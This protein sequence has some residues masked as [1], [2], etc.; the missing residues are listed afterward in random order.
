MKVPNNRRE[1]ALVTAVV[2]V[3]ATVFAYL[4]ASALKAPRR[5]G[6]N[7]PGVQP[8][9]D[10]Q[11]RT[12]EERQIYGRRL[13]VHK[14]GESSS[15]TSK[16]ER[17][18]NYGVF[19]P[20][21]DLIDNSSSISAFNNFQ[22]PLPG[23]M[24]S[25][26]RRNSRERDDEQD[27]DG[28]DFSGW[29]WLFDDM[30]SSRNH[31]DSRQ[32]SRDDQAKLDEENEVARRALTRQSAMGSDDVFFL[33][34]GGLRE[35][36]GVE[37]MRPVFAD[38]AM[39]S[40]RSGKDGEIQ[41]NDAVSREMNAASGMAE[42]DDEATRVTTPLELRDPFASS[43]LDRAS[44]NVALLR[45]SRAEDV[46]FRGRE[47]LPIPSRESYSRNSGINPAVREASALN[48]SASPAADRQDWSIS[49]SSDRAFSTP[50]GYGAIGSSV[51][52]P[53]AG[54]FAMPS[55]FGGS[56]SFSAPAGGGSMPGGFSSGISTPSTDPSG[57]GNSLER[58]G[59]GAL[60]W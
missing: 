20:D 45:P 60:P 7:L 31:G 11:Q 37:V 33:P 35:A 47:S 52:T 27:E 34:D 49:A 29:G 51:A 9:A 28:Q 22:S 16:N 6:E 12:L 19:V 57:F 14:P 24:S 46:F 2:L 55:A 13:A 43:G 26:Q 15:S 23:A 39:T 1:I 59:P 53:P 8:A 4:V 25:P 44:D 42:L 21:N 38:E 58:A 50:G 48:F 40:Q 17:A 32:P 41:R 3:V 56:S 18:A 54:S 36:G 5:A 30:E 10:E